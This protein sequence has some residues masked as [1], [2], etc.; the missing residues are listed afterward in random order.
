MLNIDYVETDHTSMKNEGSRPLAIN[1]KNIENLRFRNR[2]AVKKYLKQKSN[3]EDKI[4]EYQDSIE[5]T[6]KK[7]MKEIYEYRIKKL[8]EKISIID[9][10]VSDVVNK[11]S[12]FKFKYSARPI[13]L[14]EKA[15]NTMLGIRDSIGNF[16]KS[17]FSKFDPDDFVSNDNEDQVDVEEVAKNNEQEAKDEIADGVSKI[18]DEENANSDN[19]NNNNNQEDENKDEQLRSISD[20]AHM[21]YTNFGEEETASNDEE[22]S[23]DDALEEVINEENNYEESNYEEAEKED[24]EDNNSIINVDEVSE[25]TP[26]IE[27][28][29]T[30]ETENAE[31]N[32]YEERQY[33]NIPLPDN[34]EN[35]TNND[36]EKEEEF[37]LP[38]IN[39]VK[40]PDN[41]TGNDFRQMYNEFISD[42][43]VTKPEASIYT[44]ND[45][46][47]NEMINKEEIDNALDRYNDRKQQLEEEV[48]RRYNDLIPEGTNINENAANQIKE[49]LRQQIKEEEKVKEQ[50][51]A[52]EKARLEEEEVKRKVEEAANKLAAAALDKIKKSNQ[53]LTREAEKYSNEVNEIHQQTDKLYSEKEVLD[54]RQRELS[55]SVESNSATE[56][57][58][59]LADN[60]VDSQGEISMSR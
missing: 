6:D 29:S 60:N 4:N 57:D 33:I 53:K 54:S 12:N 8:E 38:E 25:E 19:N 34:T 17:K 26:D 45:E 32:D 21:D 18:M 20:Y 10:Y 28:T 47:G 49:S 40:T 43:D 42:Y 55:E 22:Q 31:E 52:I 39:E 35:T 58:A 13:K 9:N 50:K 30:D 14:R 27:E 1:G 51:E 5:K 44:Y 56:L 11:N 59:M 37:E 48:N 3:Y 2:L 46:A 16:F 23:V 41:I 24:N 15:W 7:V 36:D